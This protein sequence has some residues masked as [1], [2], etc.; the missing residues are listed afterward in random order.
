V[1]FCGVLGV[2]IETF[3]STL[4]PFEGRTEP[5]LGGYL[6]FPDIHL[7]ISIGISKMTFDGYHWD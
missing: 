4:G 2:A 3:G 7:K 1:N 6:D 5:V